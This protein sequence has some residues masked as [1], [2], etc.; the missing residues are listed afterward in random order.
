MKD[1]YLL[2]DKHSIRNSYPC[3]L[4][5]N[6]WQLN[7]LEISQY[8]KTRP[9]REKIDDDLIIKI[10]VEKLNDKELIPDTKKKPDNWDY[11]TL[12]NKGII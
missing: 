6:D 8:Y 1:N 10:V 12:K 7:S 11:F 4:V 2:N 5:I 3:D 9:G